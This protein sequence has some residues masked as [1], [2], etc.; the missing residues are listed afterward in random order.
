MYYLGLTFILSSVFILSACGPLAVVG[1]IGNTVTN[2]A[3]NAEERRSRNSSIS[4]D[5][6]ATDVAIANLN[7]GVAYM[8][9]GKYELALEKMQRAKAAKADYAPTYNALGL[10]HQQ[11][12]EKEEAE[13]NFK[14]AIN[15]D[16]TD[17]RSRNNYGF[18]LCQNNRFDEAEESFLKAANNP[19][20]STPEVAITNAGTCALSNDQVDVAENYFRDAL[21]RNPKIVPAHIQMAELSYNQGNYLPARGYLQRYLGATKHTPKSLWL[22]I[23]IERELGDK[24]AVSSYALLLRNNYSDTKEAELLRASGAR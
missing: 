6:W 2:A 11:L 3:Y 7:L 21:K 15:L 13:K 19:F 4:R 10:L 12:G 14:R 5:E 18:F 1:A 22:G 20:N 8:Q 23:R 16:P 17:A 9:Q 24:D